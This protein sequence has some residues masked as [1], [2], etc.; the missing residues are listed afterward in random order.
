MG[1]T[2]MPSPFPGMDPWLESP[3]LFP[4]LHTGFIGRLS[5][6]LN[7]ILPEPFVAALTTRV[8]MESSERLVEPDVDILRS[9]FEPGPIAT[10]PNRAAATP[11]LLLEV[12]RQQLP[13]DEITE[14]AIDIRTYDET[15]RLIT[16]IE[17]LSRSNKTRGTSG[18]GLYLAKQ[19]ELQSAGVNPVEI[20]LLRA[21]VHT[22]AVNASELRRS[23]NGYDYHVSIA[24]AERWESVFVAAIPLDQRLPAIPI[25]LVEGVP[26]VLLDLQLAFE[27]TYDESRY[28]RRVRYTE[29]CIPRLTPDQ[30]AWAE[31]VLR[32]K[33]IIPLPPVA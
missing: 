15:E 32:D 22:T 3:A 14:I 21:G 31:A 12:P 8:Y 23:S 27:Q 5:A 19:H 7:S 11:S 26:D 25:P 2:A 1:E 33:K 6:L 30:Q 20:D 18:R 4:S 13:N 9:S 10:G 16:S 29:P 17:V 24:R 28:A